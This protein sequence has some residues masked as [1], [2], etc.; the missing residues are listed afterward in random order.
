MVRGFPSLSINL[1]GMNLSGCG[2]VCGSLLTDTRLT[3][4]EELA[5]IVVLSMVICCWF[6]YG[7]EVNA[8]LLTLMVSYITAMQYGNIG[9]C[10]GVGRLSNPKQT[11]TS[12]RNQTD[13]CYHRVK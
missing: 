2:N 12:I 4:R 5:G 13:T 6:V 11:S 1:S 10:F 9:I 7:K 3:I 8:T